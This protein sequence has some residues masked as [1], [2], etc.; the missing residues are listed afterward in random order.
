MKLNISG[1]QGI[2]TAAQIN[3]FVGL[4]CSQG[5]IVKVNA[6]S[7][8]VQAHNGAQL[9]CEQN[10]VTVPSFLVPVDKMSEVIFPNG[11]VYTYSP[12]EL[13][14]QTLYF[15]QP[16][17]AADAITMVSIHKNRDLSGSEPKA[18]DNFGN[19]SSASFFKV[20]SQLMC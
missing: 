17:V 8:I 7:V 1:A 14:M 11:A 10:E 6:K 19:L 4:Q 9:K 13:A 15:A 5:T 3:A 2:M 12:L 16:D 18:F 20:L